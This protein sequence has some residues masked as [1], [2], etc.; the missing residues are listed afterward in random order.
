M[1]VVFYLNND[2]KNEALLKDIYTIVE[3]ATS[4]SLEDNTE[5]SACSNY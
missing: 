1:G 4:A 5:K 2:C 3:N